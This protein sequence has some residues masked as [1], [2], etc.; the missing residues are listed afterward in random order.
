VAATLFAE[1]TRRYI[2]AALVYLVVTHLAHDA[3]YAICKAFIVSGVECCVLVSRD[4]YDGTL[5]VV[6]R[7]EQ[8]IGHDQEDAALNIGHLF[9]IATLHGEALIY[10]DGATLQLCIFGRRSVP[11]RNAGAVITTIV[12]T[13]QN[14]DASGP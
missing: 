1:M 5:K 8:L 12:T 11:N 7:A 4:V 10:T 2:F 3:I 6:L 14:Q 9:S 13:K